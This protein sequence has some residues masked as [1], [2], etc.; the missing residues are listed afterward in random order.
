LNSHRLPLIGQIRGEQFRPPNIVALRALVAAAKNH[1]ERRTSLYV[2]HTVSGT[3]INFQLDHTTAH[4]SRRTRIPSIEAIE[5]VNDL[6]ACLRISQLFQPL[7]ELA[8]RRIVIRHRRI[9]FDCNP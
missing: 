4:T 6:E 5:P 1:C 2:I 7:S 3:V 8:V 9:H